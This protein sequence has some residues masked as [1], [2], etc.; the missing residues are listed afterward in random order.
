MANPID[1]VDAPIA[2][3]VE[4]TLEP[5]DAKRATNGSGNPYLSEAHLPNQKN[6]LDRWIALRLALKEAQHLG[7]KVRVSGAAVVLHGDDTL[8]D[9]LREHLQRER[10]LLWC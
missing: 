2:G 3:H 4:H 8:P 9:K 7:L 1:D 5:T 6:L 10:N